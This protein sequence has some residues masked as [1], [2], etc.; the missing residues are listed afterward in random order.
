MLVLGDYAI[1]FRIIR[2]RIERTCRGIVMARQLLKGRPSHRK[3]LSMRLRFTSTFVAPACAVRAL[4]PGKVAVTKIRIEASKALAFPPA[5][6]L[7]PKEK[8]TLGCRMPRNAEEQA[9]RA[10]S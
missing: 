8:P 5:V 1:T 10:A 7:L 9:D 4:P 3:R 6:K 2:L